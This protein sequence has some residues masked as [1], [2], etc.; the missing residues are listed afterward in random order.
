MTTEVEA[1]PMTPGER[2]A[3]SRIIK[4]TFETLMSELE[5]LRLEAVNTAEREYAERLENTRERR[6]ELQI[7]VT[8]KLEEIKEQY[9]VLES[10]LI[11][12]GFEIQW[13]TSYYRPSD[14][15]W[16]AIKVVDH[17]HKVML[18]QRKQQVQH[19]YNKAVE[20][21]RRKKLDADKDLLLTAIKTEE[22]KAFMNS[23]PSA[24]SLFSLAL[25]S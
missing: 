17:Q 12:E 23:L 21:L 25:E 15:R 7:E 22:A 14:R 18:E 2:Q 6:R 11:T 16:S 10:T 8:A 9:R 13:E 5:T 19:Q 3:L 24:V 1:R 20:I 4:N